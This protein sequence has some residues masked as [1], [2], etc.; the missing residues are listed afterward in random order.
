MKNRYKQC[1]KCKRLRSRSLFK[2]DA[3]YSK[4]LFCWCIDC[5]A[6]YSKR[7]EARIAAKKRWR[8]Y[9]SDP[10]NREYE[11]RRGRKRYQKDPAKIKDQVLRRQ[12]GISLK[13]FQR[14]KRCLL[15]KRKVRLVADHNHKTGKYRGAICH[16]C[17]LMIAWFERIRSFKKI[18]EYLK[19]G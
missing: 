19:R 9:I 12:V 7:P 5:E 4:G 16:I 8:K 10:K 11:R 14:T 17:N 6:D 18:R 1:S 3:R 15:C 2:K 13:K